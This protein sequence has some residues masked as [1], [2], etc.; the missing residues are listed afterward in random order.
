MYVI[1][2]AGQCQNGKDVLANKLQELLNKRLSE[3]LCE[4]PEDLW[5]RDSFAFGVKQVLAKMFGVDMDFIEKWKVTP[6]IPPGFDMNIRQSLQFIGD[7]FRKIRG[8]IW[9]DQLFSRFGTG[10]M[11]SAKIISDVR[12]INEFR[13]IKKEGGI[14]IL[15]G[16]TKMLNDDP[17]G[18]EAIIRPYA[19]W[20]LDVFDDAYACVD[21]AKNL[22][23]GVADT[24]DSYR[25]Y[26]E[27]RRR[28][29]RVHCPVEYMN[30]FDLFVRNDGTIEDLYRVVD[31]QIVPFVEQ[32][33]FLGG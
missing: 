10:Q 9:V 31:E 1:G 15:I 11:R 30:E 32:Y 14:N 27:E 5:G 28:S 25:I 17:N 13:R 4:S 23:H 21:I 6:E 7:G 22:Y 33:Q 12:Y 26:I 18:S 24:A 3:G 29:G 19:K 8:S 20:C 16:R 2:V